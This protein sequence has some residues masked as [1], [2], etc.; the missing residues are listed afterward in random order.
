[1]FVTVLWY[2]VVAIAMSGWG[3]L[4]V[5]SALPQALLHGGLYVLIGIVV[6]A[7][8]SALFILNSRGHIYHNLQPTTTRGMLIGIGGVIEPK[9]PLGRSK[10][11]MEA[12]LPIDLHDWYAEYSA[13]YPKHA[14][15]IAALSQIY[16]YYKDT[17]AS[18]VP[19]G[20]GDV[21]LEQHSYNVLRE[22]IRQK[23]GWEY[24]G[25]KNRRGDVAFEILDP[26][27]R[28][29]AGADPMTEICAFAH[30]LGKIECYK[31]KKGGGAT[32]VK[33]GHDEVGGR[34]LAMIQEFW[35]LDFSD[36]EALQFCTSFYHN[37][38]Q[39]PEWLHDRVRALT[40]FTITV[41]I[42]AGKKE[43]GQDIESEY[44][45]I[46]DDELSDDAKRE[47]DE[48]KKRLD[49]SIST[50][51]VS[52]PSQGKQFGGKGRTLA[53][54]GFDVCE[55]DPFA[56]NSKSAKSVVIE[57][58]AIS[59]PSK[60]ESLL[61]ID[62][63][64]VDLPTEEEMNDAFEKFSHA[65]F[66][67]G[68]IGGGNKNGERVGFKANGWLFIQEKELR[69]KVTKTN[70]GYK[71]DDATNGVH[72]FTRAILFRLYQMG[73]LYHV[74]NEEIYNPGE[75]IFDCEIQKDKNEAAKSK[76][77]GCI[78]VNASISHFTIEQQDS[79]FPPRP[80]APSIAGVVPWSES[81]NGTPNGHSTTSEHAHQWAEA[82]DSI[83]PEIP[84]KQSAEVT[85]PQG[86]VR[87]AEI[88]LESGTNPD[89]IAS[90]LAFISLPDLPTIT[91]AEHLRAFVTSEGCENFGVSAS[92]TTT[93]K[94]IICAQES[95]MI[96]TFGLDHEAK[97]DG[98]KWF[99]DSGTYF[100][101][102]PK[103]S[104]T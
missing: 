94:P 65:V 7:F 1:M 18:P 44:Q 59:A 75:A 68:S 48:A 64:G 27:F 20:H 31:P 82:E 8:V 86:G 80:Y 85:P 96:S 89:S 11:E 47:A 53:E 33:M 46:G 77:L 2:V 23:D 22:A 66:C 69:S 25:M 39:M 73:V 103:Q 79:K 3:L 12:L 28:F 90:E 52:K 16:H 42:A 43:G 99:K 71:V 92:T 58:P 14:E 45:F 56:G 6:G 19:G 49:K 67:P 15:L 37:P 104:S 35:N 41:D 95:Y 81:S 29:E 30:D 101:A 102:V 4:D 10:K 88:P 24:C 34:M 70:Q 50:Q 40:E 87:N 100:F 17:P 98:G 13:T 32:I 83:K 63:W 26:E 61:P 93:G 51:E 78:I 36:R 5:L 21:S 76:L 54:M 84:E 91:V 57:A 9:E 62:K 97:I 72:S 74:H 55:G 60:K 38:Q